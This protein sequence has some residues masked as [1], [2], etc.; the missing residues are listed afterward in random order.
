MRRS[1]HDRRRAP[2]KHSVA[3]AHDQTVR[4]RHW[5]IS[6]TD[7]RREVVLVLRNL[8]RVDAGGRQLGIRVPGGGLR[9]PLVVVTKTE[10]HR[11]AVVDPNVILGEPCE[12]R[13]VRFC[14]CSRGSAAGESLHIPPTGSGRPAAGEVCETR[15]GVTAGEVAGKV[16]QDSVDIPV[17]PDL[18]IVPARDVRQIVREL[19]AL[20]CR[21]ARAEV[22][23][24]DDQNR[25]T[26]FLD[27]RLGPRAIGRAGFLVAQELRSELIE[28]RRSEDRT[29]GSADGVRLHQRCAGVFEGILL[30]AIFETFAGEVLLVIANGKPMSGAKLP[31]GLPEVSVLV[32]GA[33]PALRQS[34]ES[35]N[36]TLSRGIR[37]NDSGEVQENQIGDLAALA[38]VIKEEKT[39][40]LDDRSAHAGAELIEVVRR[41]GAVVDDVNHVIRVERLVA[42]KLEG[43]S[44]Q[45]V[46]SRLGHDVDHGAAGAAELRRITVRVDLE[47]FDGVLTELKRSASGSRSSGGLTEKRIVV[48]RSI[49]DETVQC[50]ALSGK[51]DIAGAHVPSDSGCQQ[52]EI[53]KVAAVDGQVRDSQVVNG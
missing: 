26:A 50:A 25:L 19:S 40:V 7:P 17:A 51:T 39:L 20:D 46:C 30:P 49:D 11:Q 47:F 8:T 6:E 28:H 9:D 38:V 31:V 27:G 18:Q 42:I 43:G 2:V 16:V 34:I 1:D 15:E 22:I 12:F 48:V 21:F 52:H 14:G 24:A 13:Q 23:A 3:A 44:V 36:R 5:P 45:F 32:E 37:R 53:D 35:L 41:P 33:I 4:S 10:I 29:Q